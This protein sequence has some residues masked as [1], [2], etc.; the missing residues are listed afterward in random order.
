MVREFVQTLLPGV[1]L[2]QGLISKLKQRASKALLSPYQRII[3]Q[4]LQEKG[5]LHIDATGWRH[6]GVNEHALVL[7]VH[8]WV[9]FSFVRHQNKQTLKELLPKKGLHIVTDRGLPVS[10]I[11]ARIHQYCLAHLLRTLKGLAEHVGTTIE[12][13]QKIGEIHEAIQSLFIDKH[14]MERAEVSVSTWRQ[15]GYKRWQFIEN[16]VEDLLESNPTE[17]VGRALRKMRKGWAHFKSYLR[18]PEYPITNNPAEKAL[19][20]LV[21]ARKLCFGSRS[22]YGRAWRAEIQSC[23]E[24]LHKP[25]RCVL[26]FIADAI[27]AERYGFV[28]PSVFTISQQC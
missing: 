15:Y 16:L 7:K 8:N 24:T 26:N 9:A 6:Q 17:K 21:I 28:A 13:T 11:G 19:R 18:R 12:E 3:E 1:D 22:E 14:R 23:I 5:P 10:E 2:S 27:C 25:G 4:V 20:S